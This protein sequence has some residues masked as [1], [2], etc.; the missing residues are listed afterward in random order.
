VWSAAKK[1]S[2][3]REEHDKGGYSCKKNNL[4][5]SR[6]DRDRITVRNCILLLLFVFSL[7]SSV[8]G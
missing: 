7:S 4:E 2:I 6:P 3:I 5:L 8:K 1:P